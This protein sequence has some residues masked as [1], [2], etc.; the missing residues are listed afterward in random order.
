MGNIVYLSVYR[1]WAI[2]RSRLQYNQTEALRLEAAGST[3]KA[4]LR[5]LK[6][7]FGI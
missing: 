6:E 3:N 7:F 4:C 5:R 2:G 1:C